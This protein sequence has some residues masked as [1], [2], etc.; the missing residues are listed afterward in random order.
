METTK[1][2]ELLLVSGIIVLTITL[3]FVAY[4][5]LKEKGVLI[6]IGG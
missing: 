2:N 1:K 5:R 4:K 3:G 6:T